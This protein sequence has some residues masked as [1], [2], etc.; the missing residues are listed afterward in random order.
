VVTVDAPTKIDV[1]AFGY[2]E[3]R[4]GFGGSPNS[5]VPQFGALAD[6][7]AVRVG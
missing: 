6:V 5:A 7:T 2:N 3:D 4:S 1:R